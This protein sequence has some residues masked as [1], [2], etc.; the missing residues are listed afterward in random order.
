M[1]PP[2]SSLCLVA[3]GYTPIS[4]HGTSQEGAP[5]AEHGNRWCLT[6]P[7]SVSM[8][9]P[10]APS[11]CG[12][13]LPDSPMR[14]PCQHHTAV[15]PSQKPEHMPILGPRCHRYMYHR[16]HG[17]LEATLK[18]ICVVQGGILASHE[19]EPGMEQRKWSESSVDLDIFHLH[20][21]T[22]SRCTVDR[23]E[24][25]TGGIYLALSSDGK[26]T[27]KSDSG[28]TGPRLEQARASCGTG[29]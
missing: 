9:R 17:K 2:L 25:R 24:G 20:P 22:Q 23:L 21:S 26:N 18:S 16:G 1:S 19:P 27:S 4:A 14:L 7:S 29:R 13:L 6:F 15:S 8:F 5:G 11:R 3:V 10:S 12:R 28:I